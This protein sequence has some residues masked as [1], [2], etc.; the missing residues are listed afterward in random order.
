MA[1]LNKQ[2]E[3]LNQV[4]QGTNS[5]VFDLLTEKG[6]A[7]FFP[8]QGI[9]GQTAEAKGKKLNATIGMAYENDGSIMA[10]P[11]MSSKIKLEKDSVFPYASSFG[12]PKLRNEWQNRI[13]KN[14]PSIKEKNLSLPVITNAVTHALSV[15]GY[16]FADADTEI[17][18]PEPAWDNY[19]LIF[20]ITYGAKISS[21]PLF[22]N[23]SFNGE[24][25]KEKLNRSPSKKILLLN[26]PNNPTGYT[27]T[28]EEANQI[29]K[30]IGDFGKSNNLL[31]ICDD[32]YFGLVY[33]KGIIRESIFSKLSA[34]SANVLAVKAD[35]VTKEDY[36]WGLRVGFITFGIKDGEKLYSALAD[37]AAGA[38]RATISNA[39]NLSQSL[40]LQA[41][42][43]EEYEL[44]KKEKKVILQKRYE[45]V[46]KILGKNQQ[47]KKYFQALPYNS[48]Y[49][50]CL[51][52][53]GSLQAEQIRKHL[54]E[55]YDTGLIVVDNF[56]RVA[57]SSLPEEKLENLFSN[58]YRACEDINV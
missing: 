3:L 25:L 40:I 57:F 39:S 45:A 58:I 24:G 31:V 49:F 36:A 8:H 56:L 51:K 55:K 48:G 6:K 7:I 17:I 14:N 32:A 20:T 10:L 54:L 23:G 35:G 22:K 42:S 29:V 38:V 11:A 4:I 53:S 18:I 1:S 9:L 46:K 16:L 13:L 2:A 34:V 27:P 30:I 43:A 21:F 28:E 44:E 37:K 50:M 19:E 52:L 33:E 41:L 15:I 12:N 5:A 47:Y 26:F